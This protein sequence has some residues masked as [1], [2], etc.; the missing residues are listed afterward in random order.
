MIAKLRADRLL[1]S[2]YGAGLPFVK[3]LGLATGV[4]AKELCSGVPC[5]PAGDVAIVL[6]LVK[7]TMVPPTRQN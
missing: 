2:L 4:F 6:V 5:N 1:W 7:V 3:E